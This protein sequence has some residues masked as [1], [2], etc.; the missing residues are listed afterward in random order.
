MIQKLPAAEEWY[1]WREFAIVEGESEPRLLVPWSDPMQ[2]EYAADGIFKSVEEAIA[3]RDEQ[4]RELEDSS[5]LNW[6]LC[7]V[8]LTPVLA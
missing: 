2:Y 7:K 5:L 3:W 4:I 1:S 8:S 6:I